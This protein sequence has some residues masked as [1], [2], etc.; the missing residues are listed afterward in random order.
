M[1]FSLRLK[2][3]LVSLLLLLIPLTGFRF[4][5]L[6]KQDLLR[7]RTE[8]MLFSAKAVASALSGRT[9]LFDREL[10]HSLS[11]TRDLYLFQ[12]SNPIRINGKTDDW[13]PELKQAG[14]FGE[15][16]LLFSTTPYR[17]ESLHYQHLTGVR[18][19]YLYAV[20]LVTDDQV[21]YRQADSP[22]QDLADHLQIGVEDQQGQLHQYLLSASQPGWVNG[23]LM[24][25]DDR[26]A[27]PERVEPRI[28]GMWVESAEGYILELRMPTEM[29]GRKLAF[30]IADVDDPDDRQTTALV[31]TATA[32][33]GGELGW[34]LSPSRTIE[35][36]LKSLDRPHSRVLIVDTNRRVRASFGSLAD[37]TKD[38]AADTSSL[39]T[40]LSS[41]TYRLLAPFYRFFIRPFGAD[42]ARPIAKSSTLDLAGVKEA[43]Q[44]TSSVTSYTENNGQVEIMAAIA[45]LREGKEILGAVVVEQTTNSIL[46]LRN[47]VIEESLTLTILA[48]IFGGAGLVLFASRLSSRIRRLGN[49]A[50]AA[51]SD[52]GQIRTTVAPM[53]AR[54]EIGDLS[55]TL[56]AML[57][58]LQSQTEYREKMADNLEHEM[59]TPLAGISASLKNMAR[60]ME[61]PPAH[62]TEYLNWALEDVARL[63]NLLTAVR[64]ATSLTEALGRDFKEDFLLDEAI[65]MWLVHSWRPAFPAVEFVYRRPSA[66]LTLHGDP[67]RI[68]QMLDKLI[69]NAVSFHTAGSPIE[70]TLTAKADS[71]VLQVANQG[72]TIPPELRNQIFNSMVSLRRQKDK[73]PHL[74]LGLYIVRTIVEHHHGTIS[75]G[76][77]EDGTGTVFTL[78]L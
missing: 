13:Q 38:E 53:T 54:D 14:I 1:R 45:P 76:T 3:T 56:T 58:Q 66:P 68:H 75:A 16:H 46:A 15:E 60:E 36:I 42:I 6:I 48:F 35:E 51:I 72:P 19:E 73:Q 70:I 39:L 12:L 44:G 62:I 52:S 11:P 47:K 69:E 43:L 22:R 21:I 24:P 9:G 61:N 41:Y 18:G 29:V 67:T 55:R 77:T 34:L 23:Y 25:E 65:E 33:Y 50:A 30:A 74:G 63:E 28:Q 20:F 31:G 8:T 78:T 40:T 26:I 27:T 32:E 2:L 5:E 37:E 4:S 7:S 57:R 10:F 64:D 49:Q 17:H 59:R 71:I